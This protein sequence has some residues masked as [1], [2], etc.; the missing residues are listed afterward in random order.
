[1]TEDKPKEGEFGYISPSEKRQLNR[2]GK[3][4]TII[5]CTSIATVLL[6][7]LVLYGGVIPIIIAPTIE[8]IHTGITAGSLTVAIVIVVMGIT[9]LIILL[10]AMDKDGKAKWGK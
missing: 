7:I 6:V 9:L 4:I 1:M 2:A 3:N 5:I 8:P 10:K